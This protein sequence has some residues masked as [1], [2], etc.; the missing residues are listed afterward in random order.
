MS[1]EDDV[2]YGG[3][4]ALEF[5]GLASTAY[6]LFVA[7]LPSPLAAGVPVIG[8]LAEQCIASPMPWH[9][10]TTSWQEVRATLRAAAA[11]VENERM[12][13]IGYKW[14]DAGATEFSNFTLRFKSQLTAA[15]DL[16]EAMATVANDL[17]WG[18]ALAHIEFITTVLISTAEAYAAS[19]DPE[20][21]SQTILKTVIIGGFIA[22]ATGVIAEVIN[23]TTKIAGAGTAIS[24]KLDGLKGQLHDASGNLDT[25]AAKL[26]ADRLAALGDP[27]GWKLPTIPDKLLV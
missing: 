9:G 13:L 11:D 14:S 6:Y 21:T 17:F 27:H 8:I 15:G 10:V 12:A 7:G 25:G 22:I 20:P 26:S 19:V 23:Y 24:A 1:A 18:Y 5:A 16:A 4:L 2:V 3:A